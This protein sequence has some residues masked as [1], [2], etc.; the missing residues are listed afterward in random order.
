MPSGRSPSRQA[1]LEGIVQLGQ[2]ALA[3]GAGGAIL[4]PTTSGSYSLGI[5]L[6]TSAD[7]PGILL[8][9]G[10]L[11]IAN[12]ILCRIA[13]ALYERAPVIRFLLADLGYHAWTNCVL[14]ALSPVVIVA[15]E[16]SLLLVPLLA[17]PM[18]I[19]WSIAT[20]YAEKDY[21]AYQALHDDLTGLPNRALF[22]D[23][24][25]RSLMEAKRRG[26]KVGI[27]LLDL[28]RF[29]EINDSLGHHIGDA[30]LRQIG[31]RVKEVLREV[32]TFAR[33]G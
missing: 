32:D 8:A 28:D 33:L 9:A 25:D 15:T 1:G 13:I 2:I 30:L 7:V 22:Y 27:M 26:T 19:I 3:L 17:I 23:R 21:K 12:N 11:F 16:R 31:P 4:G 18:A 20:V 14:L 5:P 10:A 6:F 29:K 24:L